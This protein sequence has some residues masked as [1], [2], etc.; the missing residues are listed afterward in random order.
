MSQSN[1]TLTADELEHLLWLVLDR[2]RSDECLVCD[3]I[4]EKL[5]AAKEGGQPRRPIPPATTRAADL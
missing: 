1:I 4:A 3:A 5:R 2:A